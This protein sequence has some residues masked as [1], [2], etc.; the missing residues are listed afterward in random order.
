MLKKVK[1]KMKIVIIAVLIVSLLVGSV[2]L[3]FEYTRKFG[4]A[5]KDGT[6]CSKTKKE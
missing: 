2:L 4:I 3:Y 5:G 1:I 6:L